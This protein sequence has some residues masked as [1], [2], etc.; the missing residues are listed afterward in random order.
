[1][2]RND[3]LRTPHLKL[4][5][6]GANVSSGRSYNMAP[7]RW[8]ASWANN[9]ALA[10]M[11]DEAGL[12]CMVPIARW[13]GYGGDSNPNGEAWE[14]ITWAAGLLAATKRINVFATVH[15]PLLHPVVAAKQMATVDHIG[16]GR[17]GINVVCGW[18]E[19]EFAMFGTD[20]MEHDDRYQQGREWWSII[21]G[22]WRGNPFD[23]QHDY[24]R[25]LDVQGEPGPF[26]GERPLM[27]NAGTSPAG[28]QFAIDLADMHFDA[29]RTPEDDVERV[30][31]TKRLAQQGGRE[32]QVW[33]PIG[34]VCRP[35]QR[36]AEDFTAHIIEHA[37]QGAVGNLAELHRRHAKDLV[38]NVSA[39]SF[40]GEGPVERRVLARGNFCA[41][42][43][44]E[45]VA[46]QIA[47][48][49]SVGF[50]GLAINFVNYLD[51]FPYFVQEVLPRLESMG[52]R[53]P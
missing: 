2:N 41:I 40:S 7:E 44:P 9:L 14:S 19:D 42:G 10:Q 35:S 6:F 49:H 51:E 5:L 15:V 33:T 43:D 25:L 50:D 30:A 48:L 17:F 37:D 22:I 45:R 1:M 20:K 3:V 36:E 4:G 13:K 21:T 18:N 31:E 23:W 28:R 11:A 16:Q 29:V 34:V 27:M 53:T 39:F 24:Y 26:G 38:D 47:R 32:L 46:S 12:E 52:V 8:D